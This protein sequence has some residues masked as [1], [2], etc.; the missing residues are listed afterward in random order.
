MKF[1]DDL[2]KMYGDNKSI[3]KWGEK[4]ADA[5]GGTPGINDKF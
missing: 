2:I 5:M 3:I 4:I 1:K